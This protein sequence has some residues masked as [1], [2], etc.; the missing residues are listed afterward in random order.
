MGKAADGAVG[1][2]SVGNGLSRRDKVARIANGTLLSTS[3][4]LVHA[5]GNVKRVHGRTADR[6]EDFEV[7]V[8]FDNPDISGNVWVK[9]DD[10]RL[11]NSGH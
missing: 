3:V 9:I 5:T 1:L 11:V 10:L 8:R 7:L 2:V 4:G 6:S